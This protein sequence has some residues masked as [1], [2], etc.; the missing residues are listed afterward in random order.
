MQDADGDIFISFDLLPVDLADSSNS[1]L[2]RLPCPWLNDFITIKDGY[3][4]IRNKKKI[5]YSDCRIIHFDILLNIDTGDFTVC[6]DGYCQCKSS[7]KSKK[8]RLISFSLCRHDKSSEPDS[9][10][11]IGLDNIYV[12]A[13]APPDFR[14]IE[15]P[16]D[17]FIPSEILT[18]APV[19]G[20]FYNLDF[21]NCN[22]ADDSITGLG[23]SSDPIRI[24]S[25][26]PEIVKQDIADH[27]E[28][29][30]LA[31]KFNTKGNTGPFFSE[32]V[33]LDLPRKSE[34][35]F[36]SFDIRT[37][38]MKDSANEFSVLFNMTELYALSLCNSGFMDILKH[39]SIDYQDDRNM[40]FDI[41]LDV[42]DRTFTLFLDNILL[43]RG[44]VT[45]GDLNSI[46][47]KLASGSGLDN[48]DD[49]SVFLDNIYISDT[50]PYEFYYRVEP[51]KDYR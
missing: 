8:L 2:L 23:N 9:K 33:R 31:L 32:T 15:M 20:I 51:Y 1:F 18:P 40:H 37:H 49:S 5:K 13:K 36:I 46:Q 22:Q 24:I 50:V 27:Q 35:Y 21:S 47:F 38:E 25:G 16:G 10:T 39:E 4:N 42:Q 7:I 28:K 17:D 43:T 29:S 34:F 45:G 30:G 48:Y 3:I 19:P 14:I 41:M 12:A 11:H 44:G 6:I 26:R